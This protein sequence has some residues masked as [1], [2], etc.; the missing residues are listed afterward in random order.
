MTTP[1]LFAGDAT[2]SG[3]FLGTA[4]H[5]TAQV[6][7]AG[8]MHQ[9][10]H[11]ASE[12]L[13]VAT[14]TKLTRNLFMIGV[15]PI[16][17]WF[18]H[19]HDSRARI[20]TQK[21]WYHFVPLSVFGFVAMT[22]VRTVGD[23]GEKP[24]GLLSLDHWNYLVDGATF[25]AGWCISIAMAA[26]GLGTS[27]TRFKELGLKPLTVGLVAAVLIGVI[28]FSLLKVISLMITSS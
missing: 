14:V 9:Q 23:M 24:F 19:H 3:M 13:T 25:L 17:A 21:S 2:L 7:G 10:Q 16:M 8:L 26:V 1:W 12:T 4:I 27:L 28:S 20:S 18:Y 11:G 15:I 5:D 22:L 6:V